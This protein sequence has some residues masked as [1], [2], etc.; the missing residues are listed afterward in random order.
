MIE[1]GDKKMRRGLPAAR[2]RAVDG[3]E[4]LFTGMYSVTWFRR[5]GGIM[6][7]PVA[8]PRF[9]FGRKAI[10]RDVPCRPRFSSSSLRERLNC[11]APAAADL[12]RGF[13]NSN[14]AP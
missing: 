6:F 3:T 14:V 7:F 4:T 10:N 11:A 12:A 8:I 1:R 9:S 13:S 5:V 2:P